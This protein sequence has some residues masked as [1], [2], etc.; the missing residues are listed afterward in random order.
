M[1]DA[2]EMS[3]KSIYDWLTATKKTGSGGQFELSVKWLEECLEDYLEQLRLAH[4]A[5]HQVAR[6]RF[7]DIQS[8]EQDLGGLLLERQELQQRLSAMTQERDDCQG[9]MQA[10]DHAYFVSQ[11]ANGVAGDEIRRLQTLV[12]LYRKARDTSAQDSPEN[13]ARAQPDANALMIVLG[14]LVD[15]QRIVTD[16][17]VPDGIRAKRAMEKLIP[18]LDNTALVEA[19][20]AFEKPTKCAHDFRRF[21]T[22]PELACVFCGKVV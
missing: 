17:L 13:V 12:Q 21:S 14:A 18:C 3:K 5:L 22:S 8:L 15:C 2:L 20:K 4:E 19:Q 7:E 1:T 16:Y 10:I 11:Q 9:R 6:K